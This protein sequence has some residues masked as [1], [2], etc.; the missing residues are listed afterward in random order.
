MINGGKEREAFI[1]QKLNSARRL[2]K[3]TEEQIAEIK[4]TAGSS[5]DAS[6]KDR[7]GTTSP[8]ASVRTD[9]IQAQVFRFLSGTGGSIRNSDPSRDIAANTKETNKQLETLPQAIATSLAEIISNSG[10]LRPA[11]QI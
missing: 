4:K 5:F 11:P 9:P 3:L 1:E 2:G 7:T 10:A 6:L 8:Q